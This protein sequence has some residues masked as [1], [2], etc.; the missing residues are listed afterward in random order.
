MDIV[1]LLTKLKLYNIFGNNYEFSCAI[2]III[3]IHIII[4]IEFV[5]LKRKINK[6]VIKTNNDNENIKI[7]I[8]LRYD[9]MENKIKLIENNIYDFVKSHELEIKKHIKIENK[10]VILYN[11]VKAHEFKSEQYNVSIKNNLYELYDLIN[12]HKIESEGN[13]KILKYNVDNFIKSMQIKS[14]AHTN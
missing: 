13:I 9:E 1:K 6:F 5:L 4:I 11:F 8:K 14:E 10:F 2:I 12:S 7:I 3:I